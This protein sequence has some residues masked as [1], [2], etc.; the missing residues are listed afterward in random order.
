MNKVFHNQLRKA[1]G[2]LY[3]S[4]SERTALLIAG[5]A[6]FLVGTITHVVVGVGL[7]AACA[8]LLVVHRRLDKGRFDHLELLFRKPPVWNLCERDT[9]YRNEFRATGSGFRGRADR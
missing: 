2:I 6:S 5:M 7:F 1:Y 3:F 9:E 4:E 8:A